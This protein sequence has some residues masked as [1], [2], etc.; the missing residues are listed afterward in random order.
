MLVGGAKKI[1]EKYH[2]R[3]CEEP[4]DSMFT[5]KEDGFYK[6]RKFNFYSNST[7]V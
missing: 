6:V 1:L 5:F 2:V 3:K 4:R 7:L